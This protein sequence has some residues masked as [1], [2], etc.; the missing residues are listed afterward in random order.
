L[1]EVALDQCQLTLAAH[2]L[3]DIYAISESNVRKILATYKENAERGLGRPFILKPE[4]EEVVI[5]EIE[6]RTRNE[7]YFTQAELGRWVAEEMKM[8]VSRGWVACFLRRHADELCTKVINPQESPRL[9][10]PRTWLTRY[11]ELCKKIIPFA[12]LDL[13]FN[14][15]EIGL[16]DWEERG[17]VQVV[18]PV[19]YA[20]MPLSYP[21]SRSVKHQSLLC[22]VNAAGDAYCPLLIVSS[23]RG[24]NVF[25]KLPIR[26]NVDISVMTRDPAYMGHGIFE[27]YI[28]ER[29]FPI[30]DAE[31][32]GQDPS[33]SAA[34]IFCDNCRCHMDANLLRLLAEHWVLVVTYPP[35]SSGIFQ[36]LDRLVFSVLKRRKKQVTKETGL[37]ATI[38]HIRRVLVAYESSTP[39]E[40]VRAAWRRTGFDYVRS[41]GEWELRLNTDRIQEFPEFSE[42]WRR[43]Y[44]ETLL[45][46]RRR[47]QV[48]GWVNKAF[49]PLEFVQLVES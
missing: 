11:I 31:R 29:F 37:D 27:Q 28:R 3:A 17:S 2:N 38:D 23:Q 35:H 40:T 39:S 16:S 36:V 1:R 45:H 47:N 12:C 8:S 19:A 18:V 6:Q 20:Q 34:V 41:D 5:Q 15:D 21:V 33:D 10:I 49:F 48:W 24:L 9:Q 4:Q 42:V 25:E 13:L 44:P 14:L 7:A 32:H 43:D 26:Q 30:L 46:P 22:L